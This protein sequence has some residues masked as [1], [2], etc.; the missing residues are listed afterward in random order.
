MTWQQHCTTI[1]G[2]NELLR[3][4]QHLY[5]HP[6]ECNH[7]LQI[8]NNKNNKTFNS[9]EGEPESWA[10]FWMLTLA[11][12]PMFE[13]W[14]KKISNLEQCN[15]HLKFI[16]GFTP[17]FYFSSMSSKCSSVSFNYNAILYIS[18]NS[19]FCFLTFFWCLQ[20]LSNGQFKL[21]PFF[22]KINFEAALKASGLY[23]RRQM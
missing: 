4:K 17:E 6:T 19:W 10:F 13:F 2:I 7:R 22:H 5:N 23:S 21:L 8:K 16:S 15:S 11:G 18:L 3:L 14:N 20:Q 12:I 9:N 1:C